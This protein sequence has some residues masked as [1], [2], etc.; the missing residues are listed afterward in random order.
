MAITVRDALGVTRSITGMKVLDGTLLR[1][2]FRVKVVDTDGTTIRTVATFS[3][4]MT[5]AASPVSVSGT[6][7]SA[8]PVPVTTNA[9]TVTPSGGTGPY[10]YAHSVLSY[11]GGGTLSF[12]N[13]ASATTTVT[14]TSVPPGDSEIATLRCTV[15]DAFGQ[16]A[17]ADYDA[18]FTN[19][20]LS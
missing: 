11:L 7:D 8:S 14:L 10:T 20:N 4:P 3:P 19:I 13:A 17:T 1:S 9:V 18:T 15:T 12:S 2:V 16:T 5:A 6:A